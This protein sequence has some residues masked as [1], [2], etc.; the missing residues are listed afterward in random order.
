MGAVKMRLAKRLL[1]DR[2]AHNSR[3]FVDLC[4]NIHI[5][6][7]EYRFVFSLDEFL[8]FSDILQKSTKDIRNY[9]LNNP[10][11]KEGKFSD[12]VMIA[13]GRQRQ[14][15]RLKNSPRPNVSGYLNND[16]AVELQEG[17]VVDEIHIHYRDFRLSVNRENFKELADAFIEARN[18]LEE[19]QI[20]NEYIKTRNP[21]AEVYDESHVE[22]K[23]STLAGLQEIEVK[24]IKSIYFKDIYN[25]WAADR[26]YLES[27]KQDIVQGEYL[28]PILV[29]KGDGGLYYIVLGHH[30][31]LAYHEL[32]FKKIS[33]VVLS[34]TFNDTEKLRKCEVLL[35][36]I[37]R[38][39]NYEYKLSSFWNDYIAFKFNRHYRNHFKR[40]LKEYLFK[41]LF[42]RNTRILARKL[43]NKVNG[44]FKS[45]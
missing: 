14:M 35:K 18:K 24:N 40:R 38:D 9:L 33:C 43:L 11:Y 22:I 10:D 44:I 42:S 30:R 41:S 27:L 2:E 8:E 23:P 36:E 3:L 13:G 5:H 39:T 45:S 31:Y 19:F 16:F 34:G 20:H 15:K 26:D 17:H 25:D 21:D 1:K 6:Y 4:E 37:D 32:G 12:L 29:S 28:P 7:R